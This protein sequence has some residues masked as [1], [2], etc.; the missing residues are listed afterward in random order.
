LGELKNLRE[1]VKKLE[2]ELETSK[3]EVEIAQKSRL[4]STTFG[5]SGNKPITSILEPA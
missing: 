1:K 3:K 2:I 5:S 4:Q